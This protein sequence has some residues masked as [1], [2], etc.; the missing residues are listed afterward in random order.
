MLDAL[1]AREGGGQTYLRNL[2]RFEP[3]PSISDLTVVATGG[4]R[5]DGA[6]ARV[7]RVDVPASVGRPL[8]RAS[9]GRTA[10]NRVLRESDADVLFTPGGL[11][12]GSDEERRTI[13]TMVR[14]LLPFDRPERA[15]YPLGYT[16]LRTAMLEPMMIRSIVRSHL[17]IFVSEHARDLL[18]HRLGERMPH[19]VVIPHGVDESFRNNPV[20]GA[21]PSWLPD[22]EYLLYVSN[23]EPYKSQLEVVRG[24]ALLK[25]L[26]PFSG[27][28][29]LV[30]RESCR[31]YTNI[32]RDEVAKLGLAKDVVFT[33]TVCHEE[34]PRAY[35]N[36]L[37]VIFASRCEN[38]PNVLLEA[39]ASGRP[40]VASSRAPMPEFA[41]DS[42][43]YFDPERPS[44][45]ADAVRGLLLDKP[46]RAEMARL[47]AIRTETFQWSATASR[48]WEAI[49][50]AAAAKGCNDE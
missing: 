38:C 3:P 1:S 41:G 33:G 4:L 42:V 46:R 27:S 45:L 13:V 39:M 23:I 31:R 49:A 48:T 21:R 18:S 6:A 28:L 20:S 24:F 47:A 8:L 11:V 19:N 25:R 10:L 2:L 44:G 12:P 40:V 9:W 16:R 43:T 37:V 14:N 15:R 5:L 50:D 36:A 35:H 29:V 7:E 17:V 34:L 22:G 30:G 32:V 26:V